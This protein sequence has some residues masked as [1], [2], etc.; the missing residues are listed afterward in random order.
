M[1]NKMTSTAKSYKEFK[2]QIKVNKENKKHQELL[3]NKETFMQL[4][5]YRI[6]VGE[7]TFILFEKEEIYLTMFYLE[8]VFFDFHKELYN[9]KEVIR[10]IFRLNTLKNYL[11]S[12]GEIKITVY[13]DESKY[14]NPLKIKFPNLSCCGDYDMGEETE[15]EIMILESDQLLE[16]YELIKQMLREIISVKYTKKNKDELPMFDENRIV[17]RFLEVDEELYRGKEYFRKQR[18]ASSHFKLGSGECICSDSDCDP[19]C[20]SDY[21]SY[22]DTDSDIDYDPERDPLAVYFDSIAEDRYDD[23]ECI[24]I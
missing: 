20:D 6:K 21:D 2:K 11:K 16:T 18:R 19:D 1:D 22:Y 9:G 3:K 23:S 14:E 8:K 24:E 5:G 4:K 10:L 12:F 13:Y 17:S 7:D 15:D